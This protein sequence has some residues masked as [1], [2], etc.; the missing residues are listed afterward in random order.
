M[1]EDSARLTIDG[2]GWVSGVRHL[3]SLNFDD[4]PGGEAAYLLVLHNISLPPGRYGTGC[5]ERLFASTEQTV[6]HPFLAL[7]AG[8]RVSSHFL[9][10]R[11]GRITQFVSCRQ[12]AWHAGASVFDGRAACNDFSV[13]VE[14]EG[15]DF[16]AFAPPQYAALARLTR[17]LRAAY[18]LRAVRGHCHIAPERKTD[19][20]PCF[21]WHRFAADAK[22]PADWLPPT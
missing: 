22:L 12:R 4:R 8:M 18:P 10:E 5:I 16:T 17:A 7:L 19:P 21:D 15:T 14:L 6:A 2:A 11:D 1:S 20:G 13:G 3:P 9:I